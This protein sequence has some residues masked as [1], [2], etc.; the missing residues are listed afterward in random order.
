MEGVS[1]LLNLA[2]SVWLLLGL[3]CVVCYWVHPLE[4]YFERM[5]RY[6]LVMTLVIAA[7]AGLMRFVRMEE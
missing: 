2:V 7:L 5:L 3:A 6:W 4:R 1:L